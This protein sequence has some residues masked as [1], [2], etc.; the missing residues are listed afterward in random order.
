MNMYHAPLYAEL[1]EQMLLSM[2]SLKV[3]V[4]KRSTLKKNPKSVFVM[5][6][7]FTTSIQGWQTSDITDMM[8]SRQKWLNEQ[9]GK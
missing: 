8:N 4:L 1:E 6:V 2:Y 7:M 3:I 9:T 5:C